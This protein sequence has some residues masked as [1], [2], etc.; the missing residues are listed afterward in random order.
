MIAYR[1]VVAGEGGVVVLFWGWL[2]KWWEKRKRNKQRE[3]EGLGKYV[4]GNDVLVGPKRKGGSYSTD[5]QNWR[6]MF[7]FSQMDRRSSG[8]LSTRGCHPAD[9]YIK[10]TSFAVYLDRRLRQFPA[11]ET[12]MAGVVQ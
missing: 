9:I 2:R 6:W 12:I 1:T 3:E 11:G 10:A 8:R 4:Q 7:D 5:E